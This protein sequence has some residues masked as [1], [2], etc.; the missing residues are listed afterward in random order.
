MLPSRPAMRD[1]AL[2]IQGI[3]P[4]IVAAV[5]AGEPLVVQAEPGAGKTTGVPLV[6]L[7]H[8]VGERGE[9]LVAQPRRIA[10]RLAAA[11]VAE[12][13][14]EPL[15]QRIGYQVRFDTVAGPQTRV[16]FVT[17]GVLSRRLRDDPR[18]EGVAAVV[19]DE[20]HERHID[21]D[22]ALAL[23]RRL[24]RTTRPDLLVV[25]MSATLEPEPVA[26]YLGGRALRC[27]GRAFDVAVEFADRASDRPLE[28]Q[29]VAAFRDLTRD[30]DRGSVL[31]FLPGVGEIRRTAEAI[32]PVATAHGFEVAQLHGELPAAEQDR[33]V[34]PGER[35]KVILSTNVAETSVTVPDV[36]AVIDTGLARRASHDAWTG[37]ATLTLAKISRASADQ[38]AGRAGRTRP[39]RCVRLYTRHD[40]ERRAAYDPPE[41]ERLDLA[42][43]CLDLRAAGLRHATAL[44]W[45]EPP[46][47]AAVEAAETLLVRLGA[48]TLQGVLT[49]IGGRMLRL[50]AHPRLARLLVE[51]DT[52]GI[53]RLGASVAALLAERP[54]R[55]RG[56]EGAHRDLAAPSDVVADL[57]LL[58]DALQGRAHAVDRGAC[59]MVDRARKQLVRSIGGKRDVAPDPEEALALALLVAFPDRVGRCRDD[60]GGPVRVALAGGGEAELDPESVVRGAPFVLALSVEERKGGAHG[61]RTVIRSAA[62]V[63]PEWLLEVFP[64]RVEE[65]TR[66]VFDESRGRVDAVQ[67]LRYE[68]LV[69]DSTPMRELPAEAALALR[70]AALARGIESFFERPEDLAELRARTAFAHARAPEVPVLDEEQA[71][72]ALLRAC[73]GRRSFGELRRVDLHAHLLESLPPE[74]LAR[75]HRLAPTHA[76]L[77]GGRRLKIHYEIDRPPWVES[78]LQDFFGMATGPQVGDTPLVVHLLAPNRRAVQVTTDL[79]GFWTRHYPALRRQLMRRYPRHE[80]PEDPATARPPPPSR[81]GRRPRAG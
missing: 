42:G 19:L 76:T 53:P 65:V 33:A 22:L 66:V 40:Y 31:V 12:L 41:I 24:L 18:L 45:F 8:G 37:L 13:L 68:G 69:L 14:G 36:V 80:W 5:E 43:A 67:E 46:A 54:I 75:L 79:A 21:S 28:S 77:P 2:P 78:W 6:L 1:T 50:P 81:S 57:A 63:E 23:A 72:A 59:R 32:A 73:E 15:G 71:R 30:P 7:E 20:F 56:S 11:R 52:R 3:V 74:A 17:E 4:L 9:I 26:A 27:A 62:M 70:D 38:R 34:R 49:A 29:V 25:V 48:V 44:E 60:R 47:A 10:A 55:R 35:P 64:D 51:A 58:E 61:P 39:G 16:R